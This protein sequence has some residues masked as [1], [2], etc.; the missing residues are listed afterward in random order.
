MPTPEERFPISDDT[1]S[2]EATPPP[3]PRTGITAGGLIAL[4]ALALF[5]AFIIQNLETGTVNLLWFDVDLP[6]WLLLVIVF[7]LGVTV[8]WFSKSRK[9]ARKR[10][11]AAAANAANS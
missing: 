5:G 11:A 2:A 3:P 6:V 9:V 10:R 1:T 8:G 7:V 4:I